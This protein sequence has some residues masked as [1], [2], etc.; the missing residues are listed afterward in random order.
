MTEVYCLRSRSCKSE[1]KVSA[2]SEISQEILT[3]LFLTSGVCVSRSVVSDSLQ[4]HGL[5]PARLLCSW[6]SPGKT[7]GVGCHFL[8]Q[9]IFLTQGLN[10]RLLHW[11]VNFF[12]F[13][14]AEPPEKTISD[15][16]TLRIQPRFWGMMK[17][18]P[19]WVSCISSPR[20]V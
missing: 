9:W 20:K 6:N 4:P 3:G 8:L 2:L 14:T 16:N 15:F 13:F 5:Q 19:Q 10:P 7:T 18:F 1:I 12:F 11:Q 17:F